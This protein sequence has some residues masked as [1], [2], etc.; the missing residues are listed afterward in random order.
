MNL[1]KYVFVLF[2]FIHVLGL[3]KA[4]AQPSNDA[5]INAILLPVGIGSCTSPLYTNVNATSVGDP[6]TPSCWLP[7]SSNNTVWFSFT[8]LLRIWLKTR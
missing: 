4:Y 6:A 5:C 7:N 3:E 8:G 2:V 1:N